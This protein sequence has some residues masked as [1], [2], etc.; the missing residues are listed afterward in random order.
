MS[1]NILGSDP[2]LYVPYQNCGW[3]DN[4]DGCC[5]HPHNATPECHQYACPIKVSKVIKVKKK[6]CADVV[7]DWNVKYP[8][9]TPVLVTRDNGDVLDTVTRSVAWE[10]CGHA[11]VMVVGISGGYDLERV[12]PK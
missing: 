9:G 3:K 2:T 4:E 8:F 7:I 1:V 10:V 12:R 5:A 6:K 11:S